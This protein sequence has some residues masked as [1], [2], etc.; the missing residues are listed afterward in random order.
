MGEVISD[1]W[2]VISEQEI[3]SGNE[4]IKFVAKVFYDQ[5]ESTNPILRFCV[6]S[7]EHFSF[8]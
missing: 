5:V 4:Y 1:E 6:W 2:T 8:S 7:G 3:G